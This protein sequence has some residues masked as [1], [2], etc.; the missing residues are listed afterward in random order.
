MDLPRKSYASKTLSR[1][2]AMGANR[3]SLDL[4]LFADKITQL[5]C[6][7]E[8]VSYFQEHVPENPITVKNLKA[9]STKD[10]QDI[11]TILIQKIDPNYIFT[12][13][14]DEDVP[15]FF[16]QMGYPYTISKNSLLAV[17]APN[18]WPSL[19]AS[20]SWLID[21]VKFSDESY[22]IED[23]NSII[24]SN[25]SNTEKLPYLYAQAYEKWFEHEDMNEIKREIV[26]I[27]ERFTDER[28]DKKRELESMTEM[29]RSQRD[30]LKNKKNNFMSFESKTT[31]LKSH[32]MS[33]KNAVANILNEIRVYEER[34]SSSEKSHEI[35][36]KNI[37]ESREVA[38]SLEFIVKNQSMSLDESLA[39]LDEEKNL[40]SAT[41]NSEEQRKRY[42]EL[43]RDC[44][45]NLQARINEALN[46][47]EK[48]SNYSG[49]IPFVNEKIKFQLVL[50]NL[51]DRG[52]E[53][54]EP[55]DILQRVKTF[56]NQSLQALSENTGKNNSEISEIAIKNLIKKE[57]I[58]E[59]KKKTSEKIREFKENEK[60]YTLSVDKLNIILREKEKELYS[61][62]DT[63]RQEKHTIGDYQ[64]KVKAT[65]EDL[66]L[67]KKALSKFSKEYSNT[68]ENARKY[69]KEGFLNMKNFI[70]FLKVTF[71][72]ANKWV[73]SQEAQ[74]DRI[75]NEIMRRKEL[76]YDLTNNNA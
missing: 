19:L 46:R 73:G 61:L 9:P 37:S 51:S 4:K 31:V 36:K 11:L 48:I 14:L 32:I 50:E 34:I 57:Q 65:N 38:D 44:E 47:L 52:K 45:N 59:L 40:D 5:N 3:L 17:G 2:S 13:R 60:I 30:D 55:N 25:E 53:P 42:K 15:N 74:I 69:V 75:R 22:D 54:L 18:S 26:Y 39:I 16:R 67:K 72:E 63:L 62:E 6:Q 1:Q 58:E 66:D 10:F 71:K 56:S 76:I 29:L 20:L 21:L 70:E 23:N 64:N 49:D 68:E 33:S 27:Q 24:L 7:K 8:I 41:S 35:L 12:G 43:Q 28:I